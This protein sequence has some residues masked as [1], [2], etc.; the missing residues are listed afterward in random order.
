MRL[1]ASPKTENRLISNRLRLHCHHLQNAVWTCFSH[2]AR[3]TFATLTLASG[4][5][6]DNV[7]KM[8]GHANVNMTR[9]YAKISEA[10]ISREMRRIGRVLTA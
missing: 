4:A 3:H 5:T 7:A 2:L 6:I 10:N 9:H 8:P 1:T